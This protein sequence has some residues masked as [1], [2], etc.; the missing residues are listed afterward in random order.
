MKT[1]RIKLLSSLTLSLALLLTG[2]ERPPMDSVQHGYRGTGMVQVINPRTVEA[3]ADN[4]AAPFALPQAPADGPKASQ[5]YK[6]VQV[7]GGLS[8]GQ[9][10]RLMVSMA[11]WI[12]PKEGCIYCHNP[13]NFAEDSKYT[14]VV[15][16]RMI[17]MTQHINA[18]W[19]QHVAD[20]GVTCY[21]CHRGNNIPKEIWF[22]R[23]STPAGANFIGDKS[24]QNEPAPSVG[25]SSLPN[26]PFTP[27][28]LGAEGIRVGGVT[29]LPNGNRHSIKQAEWTYGLMT[30][31]SASLG[32]NCTYCHN[33]RSFSSWEGNPPQ[34]ATAWYGIRM[35]RDLN[36]QYL[37]PL[38]GT[39]P[40]ERLG[41]TGDVAKVYCATC[42]QGANKPLYGAKMAKDYP[43]LQ[44]VPAVQAAEKSIKVAK[45]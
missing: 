40:H 21:T 33:T 43:E 15:A 29:A 41:E 18:D 9:F 38:L 24:G 12:A 27:F 16:R 25:L 4:N 37:E 19:T 13:A 17:Q 36:T 34:R 23:D 1:L 35:V 45:R 22:K 8:S 2:C 28:L 39:F 5:V 6:N 32:V 14:K 11:S 42:H 3:Q 10:T 7:L 31:M 44:T 26:D 30:H 20:T